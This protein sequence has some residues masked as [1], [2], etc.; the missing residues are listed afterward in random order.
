MGAEPSRA[1]GAC[2]RA[3]ARRRSDGVPRRGGGRRG[4]GGS[5]A[6]RSSS[7]A[8][9]LLFGGIETTEGMIANAV[10]H[11]LSDPTGRGARARR[12]GADRGG[13]GGVAAARAG[14]GG[15]RPL[16]HPRHRARRRGDRARATSSRS[17]S[18]GR[19]ATRPCSP[20][21]TLR[22][23]AVE[24][25]PQLAFAHGPHVCLGMHLARLEA[26]AAIGRLLTGSRAAAGSA[27]AEP[28]ARPRLPQA[29]G[30]ARPLGLSARASKPG[31]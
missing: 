21:P 25:A 5:T 2:R 6:T 16:R 27:P 26:Q 3:C 24:R 31:W 19:T 12:P 4:A 29:A 30:A 18:R 20:T 17:R 1:L 15:G 22:R 13:G 9:V 10:L 8:A 28:A 14:G 23:P 11:L 7:N